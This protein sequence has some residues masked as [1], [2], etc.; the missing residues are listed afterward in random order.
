MSQTIH[1]YKIEVYRWLGLRLLPFY[2]KCKYRFKNDLVLRFLSRNTFDKNSFTAD[3]NKVDWKNAIK[4]NENPNTSVAQ[5]LRIVDGILDKHAPMKALT[6]K[7]TKSHNKPWITKGI[8]K[9]ISVKDNI[10]KKFLK[11]NPGIDK[12]KDNLFSKFKSYRNKISNLLSKAKRTYYTDYF[13][14]NLNDIKNTWKGIKEIISISSKKSKQ[15]ISLNINKKL[16]TDDITIAN[17]FNDYFSTVA[18]RL[19]E[20]I[21]KSKNSHHNFLKNLNENSLFLTPVSKEE[22][23]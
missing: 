10:Y 18:D 9:S 11:T 3:L 5:L 6:K 1:K 21:V 19:S 22:I 16:T 2:W 15:K 13:Q 4:E 14:N 17:S 20:K 7:K 8:L 12:D 23:D